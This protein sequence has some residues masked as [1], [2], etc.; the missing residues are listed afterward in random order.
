MR[1]KWLKMM[2]KLPYPT[3]WISMCRDSYGHTNCLETRNVAM[4][5]V[6]GMAGNGA[7]DVSTAW[8]H[9][10]SARASF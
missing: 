7:P 8:H 10:N 9:R 2:S 3:I 4:A 6:A 5:H 1:E